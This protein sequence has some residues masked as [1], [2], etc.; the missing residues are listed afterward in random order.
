MLKRMPRMVIHTHTAN[1]CL[2]G[3]SI[4]GIELNKETTAPQST[5]SIGKIGQSVSSEKQ[6]VDILFCIIVCFPQ[7]YI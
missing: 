7:L 3:S 1:R 6:H 2:A 4:R 5:A